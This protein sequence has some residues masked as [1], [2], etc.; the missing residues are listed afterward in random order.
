[1]VK[2][3]VMQFGAWVQ[4]DIDFI[5]SQDV[6]NCRVFAQECA[7]LLS[8]S[9]L[10]TCGWKATVPYRIANQETLSFPATWFDHFKQDCFPSWLLRKFPAKFKTKNIEIRECYPALKLPNAEKKYY[11]IAD[12]LEDTNA[13]ND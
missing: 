8:N 3:D 1:M 4:M 6:A 13:G 10:M 11:Y 5:L 7:G 12:I 2:L 9:A